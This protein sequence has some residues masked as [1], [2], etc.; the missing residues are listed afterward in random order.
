M[1]EIRQSTATTINIGPF[2][3]ETDGCTPETALTLAPADIKLSKNGAKL[4]QKVETSTATHDANGWY[5]CKLDA[6]DTDTLGRLLVSVQKPGALPVW[7]ECHVVFGDYWDMK[8][9]NGLRAIA[10]KTLATT[11]EGSE[12]W[13]EVMRYLLAFV[14]GQTEGGGS[15]TISFRNQADSLNRIQ[16]TV[17]AN[18]NRTAVALDGS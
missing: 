14:A 16:M 2:I 1:F 10:D 15:T 11:I 5:T 12:S 6:K 17:D 13:L 9:A 18:G 3:N 4:A 7:H 8:Y